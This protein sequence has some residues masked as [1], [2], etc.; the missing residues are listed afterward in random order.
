MGRPAFTFIGQGKV[1]VTLEEKEDNEKE[2]K[3]SKIAGSS[4]FFMRVLPTL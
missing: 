1:R 2:K 3:S 4:F